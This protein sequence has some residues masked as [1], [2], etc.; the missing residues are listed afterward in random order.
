MNGRY[1]FL[2]NKMSPYVGVD[3]GSAYIPGYSK[4]MLPFAGAQIG[5]RRI[6]KTHYA[7]GFHVEPAISTKGYNEILFKLT[8]EFN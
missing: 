5:V 2:A 4:N 6:L 3:L 1:H 8:F 7:L